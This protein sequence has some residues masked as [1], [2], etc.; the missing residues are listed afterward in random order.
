MVDFD[1]PIVWSSGE[2]VVIID[3]PSPDG[4]LEVRAPIQYA[5]DTRET[6]CLVWIKNGHI[7]TNRCGPYPVIANRPDSF[8]VFENRFEVQQGSD[9]KFYVYLRPRPCSG[10]GHLSQ[11]MERIRVGESDA[12]FD[13]ED[14]ANSWLLK[15]G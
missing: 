14:E 3:G 11:L 8:S 7:A 5:K 1:K 9:K 10:C 2:E 12:G 15:Q 4:G 13:T 6:S